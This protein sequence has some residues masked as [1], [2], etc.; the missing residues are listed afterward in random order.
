MKKLILTLF[1]CVMILCIM[2]VVYVDYFAPT[3]PYAAHNQV[4]ENQRVPASAPDDTADIQVEVM[5]VMKVSMTEKNSWESI[6]KII[7]LVL[8]TYGGIKF[9]NNKVK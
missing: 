5:G 3:T 4:R 8:V 9:I 6:F 1:T 7:V 2:G